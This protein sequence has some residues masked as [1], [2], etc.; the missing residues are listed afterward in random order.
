[1]IRYMSIE[2]QVD[3]DFS[4]ARRRAFF[5]RVMS[6]LRKDTISNRLLCFDK[7]RA[8]LGA[9]TP[10]YLG[11]KVVEVAKIVGSVGRCED[12]DRELPADQGERRD[13]VEASRSSLPLWQGPPAS[14]P[15][16]ARRRLFRPGQQPPRLGRPLP[17]CR[18]DRHRRYD[19][20]CLGA[21]GHRSPLPRHRPKPANENVA[22]KEKVFGQDKSARRKQPSY[23]S[24]V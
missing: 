17:R 2:E 5:R 22:P 18:V 8:T 13:E 20:P 11:K 23:K 9:S 1:M 15:V 6:R 3:K 21:F 7:I 10:I 14:A 4:V 19:I 16:Q 12:F 24:R